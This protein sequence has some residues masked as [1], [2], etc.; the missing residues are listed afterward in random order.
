EADVVIEFDHRRR[1]GHGDVAH[2]LVTR[3][4]EVLVPAI[5]R[6]GED[7]ARLPLKGDASAGIVPHRGGTAARQHQD[8]LLEQVVL[9]FELLAGRDLTD[10]AVIGGARGFVV[11]EHAL[12]A[13]ARPRLEL[14]GAQIGYVL[15]ADDVEPFPAHEAQIRRI[16][17]GLEL[18]RQVLRDGRVLR[19]ARLSR[20]L[21]SFTSGGRLPAIHHGAGPLCRYGG[22]WCL[23]RH[24]MNGPALYCEILPP[25]G[26]TI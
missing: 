13:L 1:V 2:T 22:W 17:L 11:D 20:L 5:E 25:A 10:V 3:A 12:A 7:R 4:V 8:H 6:D 24:A 9:R 19:H 16:L 18:V 26:A 15:R 23:P 21:V 14:D